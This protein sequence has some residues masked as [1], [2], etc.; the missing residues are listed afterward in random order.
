MKGEAFE[1]RSMTWALHNMVTYLPTRFTLIVNK[2]LCTERP[3]IFFQASWHFCAIWIPSPVLCTFLCWNKFMEYSRQSSLKWN[4]RIIVSIDLKNRNYSTGG[5]FE[6]F[7][8]LL[9]YN[10]CNSIKNFCFLAEF[11][12]QSCPIGN[13]YCINRWWIYKSELWNFFKNFCNPSDIIRFR[14]LQTEIP[15]FSKTL[16]KDSDKLI[17]INKPMNFTKILKEFRGCTPAAMKI[18]YYRLVFLL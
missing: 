1:I 2:P 10:W 6:H 17:V 18:K 15:A 3:P 7:N 9:A 5:Y 8:R 12:D 16:R 14:R 4:Q 11:I 13:T